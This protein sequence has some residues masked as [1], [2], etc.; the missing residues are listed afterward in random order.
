MIKIPPRID[1]NAHAHVGDIGG[2][3]RGLSLALGLG[4]LGLGLNRRD[5]IGLGSIGFG[6]LLLA[7]G[8][9]GHCSVT[10][11]LKSPHDEL[12]YLRDEL[13]KGKQRIAELYHKAAAI[14]PH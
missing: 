9:T 14:A 3:E 8:L 6:A 4:L 12:H 7:R 10:G 11:M 2:W 5:E 13:H 1:P